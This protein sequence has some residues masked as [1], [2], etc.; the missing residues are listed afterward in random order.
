MRLL[1]AAWLAL[2]AAFSLP[3]GSLTTAAH[4]ERVRPPRVNSWR[5][6]AEH[7]LNFLFYVPLVPIGAGVGFAA[8]PLVGAGVAFS[9]AA[10]AIQLF[11]TDR[12]P[13]PKDLGLNTAG[14]LL[15]AGIV[16]G[17]RAR[18]RRSPAG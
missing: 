14:T 5:P 11:S 1:L 3:W 13:D 4:W 6:R 17:V 9:A 15:G 7:V 12:F 2:W 10:E 8:A 18:R 16:T